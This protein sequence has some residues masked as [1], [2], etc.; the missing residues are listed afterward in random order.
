MQMKCVIFENDSN[1]FY[2]YS[3]P[4]DT[5][6]LYPIMAELRVFKTD[7][8][9]NVLRYVCKVKFCF[10]KKNYANLCLNIRQE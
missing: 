9:L 8:E 6:T 7:Y 4:C 10:Q 2:I 5:S 1:N 3:L